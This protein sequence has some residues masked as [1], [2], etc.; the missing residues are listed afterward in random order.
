[1]PL[2][3]TR[4]P[5]GP[6]TL[7]YQQIKNARARNEV[8]RLIDLA[9]KYT[10]QQSA[11]A[12]GVSKT[13]RRE[14][15][16]LRMDPDVRGHI[17]QLLAGGDSDVILPALSARVS[18][19][20]S[21]EGAQASAK[22]VVDAFVSGVAR[23]IVDALRDDNRRFA[24]LREEVRRVRNELSVLQVAEH[25]SGSPAPHE[26]PPPA[27]HF[28]GRSEVLESLTKR[29][30]AQH[31]DDGPATVALSGPP[32]V[33][34]SALM[35]RLAHDLAH[36]FPD[37]Q[38]YED[39]RAA[40]LDADSTD[41]VGRLLRA[42]GIAPGAVPQGRAERSAL[43]RSQLHD[44]RVLLLL[45]NATSADQIAPLL[46]G[47]S[48]C[49]VLLTSRETLIGITS[50]VQIELPV[51]LPEHGTALLSAFV[52]TERFAADP[53]A[54]RQ[55]ADKCDYLPL[56]LCIVGSLLSLPA[57]R[58]TSLGA[59]LSRLSDEKDRLNTLEIP[60]ANLAIR[61]SFELSYRKLG[62]LEARLFRRLG[63]LRTADFTPG[64][65]SAVL[66]RPSSVVAQALGILVNAH[67][68]EPGADGHYRFHNLLRIYALEKATTSESTEDLDA[69]VHRTA[70]HLL[71]VATLADEALRGFDGLDGGSGD[72]VLGTEPADWLAWFEREQLNLTLLIGHSAELQFWP[73]VYRLVG[74][75]T[76]FFAIRSHLD[77]MTD[78]ARVGLAAARADGNLMAEAQMLTRLGS[79]HMV[80]E[81]LPDALESFQAALP[82]AIASGSP[83]RM[84]DVYGNLGILFERRELWEE[85][86]EALEASLEAIEQLRPRD[87]RLRISALTSLGSA[88]WGSGREDKGRACVEQALVLADRH[89]DAY[90]RSEALRT[91]AR[92]S[93]E[94]FLGEEAYEAYLEARRMGE[95][96]LFEK[97]AEFERYETALVE[98]QKLGDR[99]AEAICLGE[100]G[101]CCGRAGRPDVG[102]PYLR[103]SLALYRDLKLTTSQIDLLVNLSAMAALT[104]D[105]GL[106]RECERELKE[107]VPMLS[108]LGRRGDAFYRLAHLYQLVGDSEGARRCEQMAESSL[109][110]HSLDANAAEDD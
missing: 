84:S 96:A 61:S 24:L 44:K 2:D 102:I 76:R 83:R 19:L 66:E 38:L 17:V 89:K 104:H 30:T 70:K 39:L 94:R 5:V 36:V 67:L 107:V 91:L 81:E 93:N 103:A 52:D 99:R 62:G 82:I 72:P 12:T 29:V 68:I 55:I 77:E 95:L 49:C 71:G 1:M 51:L 64:M 54:A 28:T 100:M 106:L 50:A 60:S 41:T 11:V 31:P 23:S 10:L 97:N 34:K 65:A 7:V 15:S 18:Q 56:A 35:L 59:M 58:E 105:A 74:C 9:T 37:G 16:D 6:A 21:A 101:L 87:D 85:A 63:V 43:L 48:A 88:L 26:L 53:E 25:V 109:R 86:V 90:G 98:A 4:L 79:V 75:M 80:R 14:L 8:G 92:L 42:L 20:V 3:P 13:V 47:T 108:D 46:P 73:E 40:D 110:G 57:E 32:G 45:D 27:P 33:G 22:T 69:T 78:L